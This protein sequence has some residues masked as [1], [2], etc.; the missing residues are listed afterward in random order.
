MLSCLHVR[1][2][3]ALLT[4]SRSNEL[5][6]YNHEFWKTSEYYLKCRRNFTRKSSFKGTPLD[7]SLVNIFELDFL[8]HLSDCEQDPR[9]DDVNDI[10]AARQPISIRPEVNPQKIKRKTNRA[11][12]KNQCLTARVTRNTISKSLAKPERETILHN[13]LFCNK[14]T[15]IQNESHCILSSPVYYRC[16]PLHKSIT[17]T[18]IL[19]HRTTVHM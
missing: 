5:N 16:N 3:K 17:S 19:I 6:G 18:T 10:L 13:R 12:F 15:Y 11:N 4:S 8:S 9:Q 14:S 1:S 7:W 2:R